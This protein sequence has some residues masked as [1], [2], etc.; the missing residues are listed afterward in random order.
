MP[1]ESRIPRARQ[2]EYDWICQIAPDLAQKSPSMKNTFSFLLAAGLTL[3][4]TVKASPA[5][6]DA[7]ARIH[8]AGATQIS[9]N[10]NFV[11]FT[12][13]F[14]CNEAKALREQTLNKLSRFPYAW[15]KERI[16]AGASDGS[17][18]LRP[19][20]DDLLKSEWFLEIR[21]VTNGVP[22]FA[23][24][25]CLNGDRAQLW[26]DNLANVS[27][28]WT[29]VSVQK[30]PDGWLLKKHLPPN[31]VGF[32]RSG[33][34]VVVGC[35]QN[36]L[37]ADDEIVRRA[38]AENGE[39]H[40]LKADLDWPGLA[41]WFPPLK[42][43]EFQK[44]EMQI[45]TRNDNLRWNGKFVLTQ[46]LLPPEK[47]RVPTN[48][49]SRAFDSFTAVRGLGPWLERQSWAQPLKLQPPFD[50]FFIWALQR[51]PFQ[52]FA[53]VPVDNATNAI[54]ELGT[55]L[56]VAFNVKL[57]QHM[58]GSIQTA[59]NDTRIDWR[60]LPPFVTPFAQA[61]QE[62]N[63][64]FLLAGLFPYGPEFNPLPSEL[65]Q[66]FSRTNLLYYDWEI[67]AARL[68]Q[69]LNLGNLALM[70]AQRKQLDIQS[71]AGKW[72]HR[73]GQPL[74]STVTEITQTAP[75]ELT[76]TRRAPAGLTAM[77]LVALADWLEATNFPGCDLRLP[78][79]PPPDSEPPQPQAPA[80][81]PASA[82]AH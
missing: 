52:T 20:L 42:K 14:C 15:F 9:A 18:Q 31:L 35:G 30:K 49:I 46:P 78:P 17:A 36:E 69:V 79:N 64:D 50:Q 1:D 57:Q 27:E 81:P 48:T 12:N 82:P 10:T 75:N 19:L 23:L 5:A 11:A 68:P 44:V 39:D 38:L 59:T 53:A 77:E 21:G 73:I 13:L 67:T 29:K 60:G 58:L 61:V 56:S 37:P 45:T 16:V 40:W 41:R 34:W 66:Q 28:S 74:G 76:F 8:F 24:A 3:A 62:P 26:Q 70:L 7:I 6:V 4:G 63:G 25:I 2:S 55:N 33:G 54:H 47:W 51:I 43:F 72:L 22:E 80:A 65:L 32:R 71:T